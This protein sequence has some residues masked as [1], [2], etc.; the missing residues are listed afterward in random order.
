MKKYIA[1]T[2]RLIIAA[3]VFYCAVQGNG[4]FVDLHHRERMKDWFNGSVLDWAGI[5][6]FAAGM[7]SVGIAEALDFSIYEEKGTAAKAVIWGIGIP[8][9]GLFLIYVS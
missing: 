7:L 6:I 5:S 1:L 8:I 9:V 2:A 4:H 3:I